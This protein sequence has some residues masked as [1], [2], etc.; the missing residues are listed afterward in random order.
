MPNTS[1]TSFLASYW[2]AVNCKK[3]R[4][5]IPKTVLNYEVLKLLLADG[6]IWSF[7]LKESRYEVS[8]IKLQTSIKFNWIIRYST[9]RRPIILTFSELVIFTKIGGYFVLST[10]KGIL[11]DADARKLHLGGVL[12]LGIF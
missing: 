9:Q 1:F 12:L 7:R 6:Y 8:M 4:F 3:I 11:N 5:C 10:T 2:S